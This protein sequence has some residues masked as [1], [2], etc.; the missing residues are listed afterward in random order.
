MA[1]LGSLRLQ[2]SSVLGALVALAALSGCPSTKVIAAGGTGGAGGSGGSGGSGGTGGADG[3][4][5]GVEGGS[6][7]TGGTGPCFDASDC[8][9]GLYCTTGDSCQGGVCVGGGTVFC[10][11]PD[12]CNLGSCDEATKSCKST[13][14]NN[15]AQCDDGDSCTYNGSCQNGTCAKGAPVDCSILDSDCYVGEC[16]AGQGCVQVPANQGMPCDD[17]QFCTDNDVCNGNGVCGGQPKQCAPVAGCFISTCDEAANTCSAVPGNDGA[18][19]DDNNA[20]T[21]GTTC[22][23]GLCVGGQPANEGAMCNDGT[24]CTTGEFCTAGVCGGGMGPTVFFAEDFS[25]NS[26]GWVLGPEWQIGA[27]QASFGGACGADPDTDHTPTADDGIAGVV[28]GG[29]ASTNQHPIYWIESPAFDTSSAPGSVFFQYYRWVTSDYAPFMQNYVAVFDGAQWVQ[30]DKF[31]TDSICLD[32][33]AW[34]YKVHDVTGLKNAQ[35]RV[36]FG[37][38]IT[39]GGVFT[40]GSWNVDDVLVASGAC[41]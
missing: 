24:S 31:P 10:P 11:S 34:T 28:I 3:G 36:R 29:N 1:S 20:C 27:A 15:G 5:G 25:D 18:Q 21:S 23:G 13:P 38:D 7:G 17:G 35:M 19:C 16:Q 4:A 41:Q 32:D 33:G 12:P 40:I 8:D 6:G 14:G 9:D 39:S 2:T 26:A 30:L 22:L 37:F